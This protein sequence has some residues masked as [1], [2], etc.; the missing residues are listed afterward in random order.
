MIDDTYSIQ[1]VLKFDFDEFLKNILVNESGIESA[2]TKKA[3]NNNIT[4]I[5]NI[6][7]LI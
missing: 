1:P 4:I 6:N 3:Q 5:N 2:K 7:E